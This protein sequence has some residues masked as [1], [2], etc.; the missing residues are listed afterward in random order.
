[1]TEW[2]I[3]NGWKHISIIALSRYICLLCAIVAF[4]GLQILS[5][6]ACVPCLTRENMH[7]LRRCTVAAAGG[8]FLI[9]REIFPGGQ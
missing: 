7:S 3:I 4:F 5:S 9:I 2:G 6:V 1:M 8:F